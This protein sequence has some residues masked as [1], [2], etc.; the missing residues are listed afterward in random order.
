MKFAA[1]L[2]VSALIPLAAQDI[3][4]PASLDKLAAK[5]DETVEVTLDASMLKIAG[6]FLS[7]SDRDEAV[8]KKLIAGLQSVLVRSYEFSS[9]GQY[10]KAD[11][12][13]VRAQV[14][15]PAWMRIVGVTS[16]RDGENVDV[17]FKVGSD[18]NLGGI[19]VLCAEPR[20]LT[21]VM[22]TGTLDPSQ[23]ATLGGHFGIPEF[24]VA[25]GGEKG[26]K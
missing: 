8:A 11:L 10:D 24:D 9:D 21:V 16:K 18:G 25:I 19:L 14:K 5:A 22:V 15:G 2:L 12:E 20:E 3:K 23:L 6:Q 17:Y 7:S 4:M 1:I 13:A 26:E